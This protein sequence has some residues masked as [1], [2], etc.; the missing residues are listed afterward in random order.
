MAS[1]TTIQSSNSKALTKQNMSHIHEM[2]SLIAF[3]RIHDVDTITK[4]AAVGLS[5]MSHGKM[6]GHPSKM[7]RTPTGCTSK[8]QHI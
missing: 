2:D 8:L 6:P 7:Q 4:I 1:V 3:A 5:R